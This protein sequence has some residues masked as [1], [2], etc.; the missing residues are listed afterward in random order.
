[1]AK[2]ELTVMASLTVS[3]LGQTPLSASVGRVLLCGDND[4]G[5]APSNMAFDKAIHQLS[6]RG[7]EVHA[8]KPHH[9][10]DFND[11]LKTEGIN[12]VAELLNQKTLAAPAKSLDDL[13]NMKEFAN[14][15]YSKVLVEFKDK[16]MI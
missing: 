14:K 13:V 3:K 6:E 9:H 8:I 7:I 2:P 4:G 15:E 11:V 10:K 5:S 12:K 16:L 1:M